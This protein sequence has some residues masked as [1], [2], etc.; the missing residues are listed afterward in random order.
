MSR[1]LVGLNALPNVYISKIEIAQQGEG[2]AGVVHIHAKDFIDNEKAIWSDQ[3]AIKNKLS[4]MF[5]YSTS[6]DSIG[7]ISNGN[8]SID[9]IRKN[10][11]KNEF[12]NGTLQEAAG[13][14]GL[15][16]IAFMKNVNK[17]ERIRQ[18]DDILFNIKFKFSI[19]TYTSNLAVFSC[20]MYDFPKEYYNSNNKYAINTGGP[21]SSEY[22]I[23]NGEIPTTT[24]IFVNADK[25]QW[26]GPVHFHDTKGYMEGAY[27]NP[28][29]HN[30]LRR[31]TIPNFK[32]IN[33]FN[34]NYSKR[35]FKKRNSQKY[36]SE[37]YYSF[38][39][40]RKL[41]SLFAIDYREILMTKTK[42][43]HFL[44]FLSDEE[45]RKILNSFK[46]IQV[47]ILKKKLNRRSLK[48]LEEHDAISS[49]VEA[50]SLLESAK[51]KIDQREEQTFSDTEEQSVMY[52]MRES[53]YSYNEKVGIKFYELEDNTFGED[54]FGLYK[55]TIKIIFK[56]PTIDYVKSMFSMSRSVINNVK[57]MLNRVSRSGNYDYKLNKIK[58]DFIDSPQ[59]DNT[60]WK[61][62]AENYFQ[63]INFLFDVAIPKE[64]LQQLIMSKI[65]PKT[66]T[67]QSIKSFIQD[68]E[69]L[70]KNMYNTFDL[71]S[72]DIL[73][74]RASDVANSLKNEMRTNIITINHEFKETINAIENKRFYNYL[75]PV[76]QEGVLMLDASEFADRVYSE[77]LKF[78]KTDKKSY[79]SYL[80]PVSVQGGA[81]EINMSILDAVD[82]R[83]LNNF[84]DKYNLIQNQLNMDI[85]DLGLKDQRF[86]QRFDL[87][88]SENYLGEDS[89]FVKYG[90]FNDTCYR[91]EKKFNFLSNGATIGTTGLPVIV[92]PDEKPPQS[93]PNKLDDIYE[94]IGTMEADTLL[95]IN[96]FLLQKIEV[97]RGF[98]NDNL[99]LPIWQLVE[100][101][102]L[103]EDTQGLFCRMTYY[104]PTASTVE[105]QLRLPTSNRFFFIQ[106][107]K[108]V[109][110]LIVSATMAFNFNKIDTASGY[111]LDGATSNIIIQSFSDMGASSFGVT[112]TVGN[113]VGLGATVGSIGEAQEGMVGAAR[114]GS[115]GSGGG[116]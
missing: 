6:V 16:Y 1:K 58:D 61:R 43:G 40:N 11:V 96:F 68:Y 57:R 41:N 105:A 31:I 2:L 95:K 9:L 88:E 77:E 13:E 53:D 103:I 70:M 37:L 90:E 63:C 101:E 22:I 60:I 25:E 72:K 17:A 55:Y 112:T 91:S 98:E 35:I 29:I 75:Q 59:H 78:E 42:Y 19:P 48:V 116:Y 52:R 100:Q 33:H 84:F 23:K 87:V 24:T 26:Y 69:K 34:L 45:F 81:T 7:A 20:I 12:S 50:G 74:S 82:I 3:A 97:F 83:K 94:R 47:K 114:G 109:E 111:S 102:D 115:G 104:D 65:Y 32:I 30:N 73:N 15:Q 93:S 44:Q 79:Y 54:S 46:V 66:A 76:D 38:G 8:V 107:V 28:S 10:F 39:F 4:F 113:A 18:G 14:L 89:N 36:I 27:H 49:R 5:F 85:F 21:I 62:A 99:G 80:S 51:I 86:D 108:V 71:S 106:P 67:L 56:D 64:N 92:H 110:P